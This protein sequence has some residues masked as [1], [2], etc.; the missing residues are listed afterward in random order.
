MYTINKKWTLIYVNYPNFVI[1]L[2]EREDSRYF[3]YLELFLSLAFD[4]FL[5]YEVFEY[6]L[7]D[8]EKYLF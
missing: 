5:Y 6:F 8:L 3:V 2:N 4:L 7:I 1:D